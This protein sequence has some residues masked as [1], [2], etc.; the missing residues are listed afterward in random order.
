VV[1]AYGQY[2][3]K[4]FLP[5]DLSVFYPYHGLISEWHL[6]RSGLILTGLSGL[7]IFFA[8]R[9]PY[10][11]VGWLWYLGMLVPVIGLVQVGSQAMADR[12]TYLPLIGL[13]IMLVWGLSD[14]LKKYGIPGAIQGIAWGAILIAL[15][16][17]TQIQVGYWRG[18]VTLFEQAIS[19][20]EGNFLAHTLLA[21][22]LVEKGEWEKGMA[23]YRQALRIRPSYVEARNGLGHL[24]MLQGKYDR[25]IEAF[26]AAL[27]DRPEYAPAMKNL[28]DVRMRQGKIDAAMIHYQRAFQ[29]E[30]EDPEL[31]NNYGVALF[32]MGQTEDAVL[33]IREALRLKPDYLEARDN[34]R[35]ILDDQRSRRTGLMREVN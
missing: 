25:A 20:T 8:R 35:K 29:Y 34:L 6:L 30:K 31:Y 3:L 4:L 24:L 13:F 16:M 17:A 18:S 11:F 2:I 10:L 26:E 21:Q 28:G 27:R 12:Y 15:T 14:L 32:G 23:H 1:V 9:R 5:I 33:K 19:N 7:A 22:A